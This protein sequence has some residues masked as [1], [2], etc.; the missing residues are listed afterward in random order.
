MIRIVPVNHNEKTMK[1]LYQLGDKLRKELSD[2]Y[3]W[4]QWSVEFIGDGI[5][6]VRVQAHDGEVV[7]LQE[8]EHEFPSDTL[9]GQMLLIM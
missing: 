3:R 8:P 4:G 6:T 5:V 9:V 2:G 7:Y 1:L